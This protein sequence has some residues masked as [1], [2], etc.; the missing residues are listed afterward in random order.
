MGGESNLEKEGFFPDC[1]ESNVVFFKTHG[2]ALE[3]PNFPIGGF[4]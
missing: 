4:S 2:A 3:F 1:I